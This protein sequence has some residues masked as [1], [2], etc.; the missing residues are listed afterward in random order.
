MKPLFLGDQLHHQEILVYEIQRTLYLSVSHVLNYGHFPG[1][2]VP[3]VFARLHPCTA[4]VI[5]L[6]SKGTQVVVYDGL[7]N[8]SEKDH[9]SGHTAPPPD[10]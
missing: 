3:H 2:E 4:E 8:P 6:G 9:R 5:A 1:Q 10:V 7:H